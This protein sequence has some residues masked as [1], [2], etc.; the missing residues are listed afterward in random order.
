MIYISTLVSSALFAV[1]AS[2][3]FA[4]PR[5]ENFSGSYTVVEGCKISGVEIEQF[6]H[7]NVKQT[8]CDKV[9]VSGKVNPFKSGDN[10]YNMCA[11]VIENC[12]TYGEECETQKYKDCKRD[13]NKPQPSVFFKGV[14]GYSQAKRIDSNYV[15]ISDC[16]LVN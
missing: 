15:K 6:D 11:F 16:T 3:A 12:E 5:C 8:A 7:V 1:I 14:F 10:P 4:T 13:Q 2:S 9:E